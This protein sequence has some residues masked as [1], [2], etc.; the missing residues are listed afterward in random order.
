MGSL[1]VSGVGL[2]CNNFGW[3]LDAQATARV[4][5]AALEA[6]ITLFDTADIYGEGRSEE[7]LG[8]ALGKRRDQVVLATKFGMDMGGGNKGAHPG[9]AVTS[10][11][12]GATSVE[13]VRHN[14]AAAGWTLSAAELAEIDSLT[15]SQG[16]S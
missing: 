9:R 14:V 10:V 3:K 13:Q 7:F 2:G 6:G 1:A 15:S 16:A 8:R 11:I 5:D 12:A 4:V